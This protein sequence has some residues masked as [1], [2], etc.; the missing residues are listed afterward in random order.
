MCTLGVNI[1]SAFFLPGSNTFILDAHE[2][3]SISWLYFWHPFFSYGRLE[4]VINSLAF[5]PSTSLQCRERGTIQVCFLF[6]D[7]LSGKFSTFSTPKVLDLILC[8]IISVMG[9]HSRCLFINYLIRVIQRELPSL[10][11]KYFPSWGWFSV[12]TIVLHKSIL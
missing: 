9:V 6:A 5:P 3:H 1:A 4:E 10:Y 2:T 7:P 12:F 11:R 8:R